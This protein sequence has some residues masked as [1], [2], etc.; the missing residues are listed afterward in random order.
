MKAVFV[1]LESDWND[2]EDSVQHE[3]AQ[4]IKAD[5]IITRNE[6]D[7]KNSTVRIMDP[8]NFFIICK[9]VKK[10]RLIPNYPFI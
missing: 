6:S 3:V 8:S 4:Q 2:F 9:I 1:G 5:L 10:Y 7:Y